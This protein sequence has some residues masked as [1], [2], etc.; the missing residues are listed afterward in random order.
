MVET[1]REVHSKK[2]D[3][4]RDKI[5]EF[6]GDVPRIELF[7]RQQSEGW[8]VWGNETDKFNTPTR[9]KRRIRRGGESVNEYLLYVFPVS[10]D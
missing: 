8:D 5:V 6:S 9:R 10:F 4:V 1:V 7:A 2:P 3:I